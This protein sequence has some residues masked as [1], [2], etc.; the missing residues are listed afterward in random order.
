MRK[1]ILYSA[2]FLLITS[3]LL[4]TPTVAKPHQNPKDLIYTVTF[5]QASSPESDSY[6]SGTVTLFCRDR[7]GKLDLYGRV[8]LIHNGEVW[9]FNDF[10]WKGSHE[11]EMRI[12]IS[13]ETGEV[14]DMFY[15]FDRQPGPNP[16]Y[17]YSLYSLRGPTSDGTYDISQIFIERSGKK[18]ALSLR[19]E[20]ITFLDL[21]FKVTVDS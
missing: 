16:K 3:T 2:I 18:G 5:A 14:M 17:E 7:G 21:D 13:K 4:I 12:F 10:N 9:I 6:I 8:S 20:H 19:G 1:T 15:G 11:G